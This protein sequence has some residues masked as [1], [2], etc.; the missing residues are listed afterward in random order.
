MRVPFKI[1]PCCLEVWQTRDD[2]LDDPFL[3]LNGYKADFAKLEYG[4]F[5]FTHQKEGCHSTMALE[6][7]DFLDLNR[8]T[9]CEQ[10]QD[11]AAKCPRSCREKRKLNQHH[12]LCECAFARDV[13]ELVKQRRETHRR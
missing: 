8:G 12:D 7:L 3:Q 10:A 4:L 6:V 2:F 5:F 1:C 11:Y 13:C 9:V